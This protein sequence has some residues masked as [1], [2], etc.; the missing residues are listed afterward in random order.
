MN[1]DNP[2][3]LAGAFVGLALM[4]AVPAM[5]VRAIARRMGGPGAG[6]AA[7][8]VAFVL[9]AGACAWLSATGQ[10]ASMAP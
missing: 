9:F 10:Q 4:A 1:L 3:A 7:F 8:L 2:A 5:M 6:R